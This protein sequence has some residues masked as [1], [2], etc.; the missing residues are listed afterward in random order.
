MAAFI[1]HDQVRRGIDWAEPIDIQRG[2]LAWRPAQC[3][4]GGRL[5][6]NFED[7]AKA[8][9]QKGETL[10]LTL[11]ALLVLFVS[12][13][14]VSSGAITNAKM[15]GNTLARQADV[16]VTDLALRQF[17]STIA[18]TSGGQALQ[19]AAAAQPS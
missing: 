7:F 8:R 6:A 15:A 1:D 12:F 5:M 2:W 4:D 11:L 18:A 17:Q 14:Y 3:E 19:L 10:L 13:L 16:Q 9:Y